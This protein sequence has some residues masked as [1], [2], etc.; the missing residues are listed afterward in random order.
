V[1]LTPADERRVGLVVLGAFLRRYVGPEPAF[2][3]LMTGAAALPASA[4][5]KGERSCSHLVQTSYLAPAAAHLMV[6]GPRMDAHALDRTAA[7]LPLRASA[8]TKLSFCDPHADSGAD[9]GNR[10]PGT[11]SGCPT[12]PD[13]SRARQLS[14]VWDRPSALRA[15]LGGLDASRFSAVY[16]RAG[17][18]F[19]DTAHNPPSL[20][21]QDF[22]VALVD[23]R[24]RSESERVGAWSNAL[25]APLGAAD[26]E[27]VMNGVW[28]PL[29][30]FHGV[31]ERRLAAVELR[32][33]RETPTGALQ[34]AE[35]G[36]QRG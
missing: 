11:A 21:A 23:T 5:P 13:R 8:L 17:Y 25:D 30:A 19:D 34:L 10:D 15:E 9:G 31:D 27:L 29:Q 12:N 1:R 16:L 6:V 2:Q 36:F 3:P 7:G 32:F 14:V 33:G 4:C 22:D 20:A 26:R 18:D 24:G 28:I 35:L